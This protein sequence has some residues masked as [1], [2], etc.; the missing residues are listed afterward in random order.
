[1]TTWTNGPTARKIRWDEVEAPDMPANNEHAESDKVSSF[2]EKRPKAAND[3]L[4]GLRDRLVI[5]DQD[6]YFVASVEGQ[7]L[8]SN[9]KYDNL[10]SNS[11]GSL[12]VPS[13]TGGRV[14]LS[15][16]I[17]SV[18]EE[19]KALEKQMT[20]NERLCVA[21][22]DR[23]YSTKYIPVFD[24]NSAMV[25]LVCIYRDKTAQ[26]IEK[27]LNN[28][29]K[30]KLEDFA[31]SSS[32]WLWEID[33]NFRITSMSDRFTTTTGQLTAML[34]GKRL[35]EIGEFQVD[36]FGQVEVYK[37]IKKRA[38]FRNQLIYVENHEKERRTFHL[39]GVPVFDKISGNYLGF[40]GAGMDVTATI[41]E[42]ERTAQASVE[43]E[44]AVKELHK[45][46]KKLLEAQVLTEAAL[47]AKDDFLGNMS[48]ELRTPLNAI[49]GFAEAMRNEVSGPLSDTYKDYSSNI[50]EA[51]G[52][53]L[54]L[55]N[56]ILDAGEIEDGSLDFDIATFDLATILQKARGDAFRRVNLNGLN[57]SGLAVSTELM[58]KAD[59]DRT[60]LIFSSILE[61]AVKHTP[62]GGALGIDTNISDDKTHARITFWDSGL[63]IDEDKHDA[64]FSKL[65]GGDADPLKSKVGGAGLSLFNSRAVARQMGG[66]IVL[67]ANIGEGARFHVLIPLA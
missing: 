60:V 20:Y 37:A 29:T 66:D 8:F 56:N 19:V 52:E 15:L 2:A 16:S 62:R 55:V 13:S 10:S 5:D 26:N 27:A 64:V 28:A 67:E 44:R 61:N 22:E 24:D 23:F 33:K 43:L 59:Y 7:M 54:S 53:L 12:P 40:R 1:M 4:V 35:D 65:S 42:R 51:G 21:G 31:R 39:S 50:V 47:S 6:P 32:D 14:E 25:A 3:I 58:V 18:M 36:A 63:G 34:V 11:M 48:H 45:Q 41:N 49:L 30:Q 9:D 17:M 57:L 46:N 38:P